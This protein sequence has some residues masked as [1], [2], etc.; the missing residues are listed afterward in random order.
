[1]WHMVNEAGVANY[2]S[3]VLSPRILLDHGFLEFLEFLLFWGGLGL[4]SSLWI[5]EREF[6]FR[7]SCNPN[8]SFQRSGGHQV[9]ETVLE[10]TCK[11]EVKAQLP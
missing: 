10:G 1:M 8:P 5:L 7:G 11:M 9:S 4:V 6:Q 3:S 2:A